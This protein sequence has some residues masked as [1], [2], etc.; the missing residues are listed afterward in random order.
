MRM[1]AM[2]AKA[3]ALS[4]DFSQSLASRRQRPWLRM[5][6]LSLLP[7]YASD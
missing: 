5:A 2:W 6:S 7:A 1:L 4:M 3:V